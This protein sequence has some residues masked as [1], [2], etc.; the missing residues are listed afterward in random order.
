MNCDVTIVIVSNRANPEIELTVQ[1]VGAQNISCEV[2]IIDNR[3]NS[4]FQ[5]ATAA[6]NWGG[7]RA[8]GRYIFFAHQDIELTDSRFLQKAVDILDGLPNLGAAGV[9]GARP[10]PE[11]GG[12]QRVNRI[13]HGV[14]ARPWGEEITRA[15]PVQ[16]L[17]ECL[18]VVPRDIFKKVRF[19]EQT[20][21]GWHLYGVDLCLSCK[22][23]GLEV[24]ALPLPI[25]HVSDGA[26]ARK[27]KGF[28]LTSIDQAYFDLFEKVRKKHKDNFEMIYTTSSSFSTG[29]PVAWQRIVRRV[30]RMIG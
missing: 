25:Y 8:S 11:K 30:R 12:V 20:C 5:S 3:N 21:D 29:T 23:I 26:S 15:T 16:T 7:D 10:H 4:K 13:T 14:P 1:S 18:L 2:I 24:Y 27:K 19:D 9:A 28:S 17:D 22:A 6:L